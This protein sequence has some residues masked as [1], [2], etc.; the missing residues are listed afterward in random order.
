MSCHSTVIKTT[1]V[2]FLLSCALLFGC[3]A[4]KVQMTVVYPPTVAEALKLKRIAIGEFEGDASNAAMFESQVESMLKSVS[5]QGKPYFHVTPKHETLSG[6]Q[7]RKRSA[8][9]LAQPDAAVALGSSLQADGIFLGS[10]QRAGVSESPY[11]EERSR[12]TQSRTRYNR[13]GKAVGEVCVQWQN[14]LVD[15]L[16]RDAVFEFAP[17]LIETTAGRAIYTSPVKE[18]ASSKGCADRGQRVEDGAELLAKARAAVLAQIRVAV[19]P[20]EKRVDAE[21]NDST[22]SWLGKLVGGGESGSLQ[23]PASEQKFA[24][25]LEFAKAGHMD[26]ACEIWKGIAATENAYI[27]LL[28]NMG[29]CEESAGNLNGARDYFTRANALTKKPDTRIVAALARTEKQLAS[30]EVLTKARPDIFYRSANNRS[31]EQDQKLY[32]YASP[33]GSPEIKIRKSTAFPETVKAG[34]TLIVGMDYS[35]MAPKGTESVDIRES[36]VLKRNGKVLKPLHDEPVTRKLGGIISELDFKIP[37]GMPP[38]TYVIEQEVGA[39]ESSDTGSAV[40][41]VGS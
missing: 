10:V 39:G 32:R 20:E 33:T 28:Y 40:F 4:P 21:V 9:D 13:K 37:Q 8:R 24:S 41:L 3:A 27:P 29:L 2:F 14:Y 31:V 34:D 26:R 35:V 7:G 18:A 1:Y 5:V 11:R 16:Q 22:S 23:S 12:C 36:M 17:R 38:G 6:L 25:G 30:N 19:A 15:C